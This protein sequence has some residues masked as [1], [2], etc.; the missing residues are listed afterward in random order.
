MKFLKFN[1]LLV[2]T[3]FSSHGL[4]IECEWWQIPIKGSTISQYPRET[5]I[6]RKHPR[7]EHC[8][9]K[10]KGADTYIKQFRND[11]IKGWP[12]KE[13]FKPWTRKEMEILLRLLPTLPAWTE[14]NRYQF[15]RAINSD[16]IDN[17]SRSEVTYGSI[18]LYDLFFSQQNKAAIITH[19]SAHHLYKKLS[20]SDIDIFRTLSGWTYEI[21]FEKRQ[22]FK[23]PPKNLI[24]P[25][26]AIGE[27]EDFTNHVE[28][29]F[30]APKSYPKAYPS[31]HK[32]LKER[33]K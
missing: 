10:W 24:Q 28:E 13:V 31:I 27:E 26:S 18:I 21:S 17:P 29:F 19:E 5:H 14:I 2:I 33:L 23:N 30:K 8:R 15:F 11:P 4:A 7:K 3:L 25:D 16:T 12:H 6:V 1:L 22:V 32:F 9:E 20:P